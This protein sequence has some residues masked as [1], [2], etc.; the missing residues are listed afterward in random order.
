MTRT[1]VSMKTDWTVIQI[2]GEEG[3]VRQFP[4]VPPSLLLKLSHSAL[5]ARSPMRVDHNN[6][7][8]CF[9]QGLANRTGIYSPD[10]SLCRITLSSLPLQQCLSPQ[11]FSRCILINISSCSFGCTRLKQFLFYQSSVIPQSLVVF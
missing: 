8:S 11:T 9:Q 1:Q 6:G 3:I 4:F 7:L 5:K 10:F 2:Y